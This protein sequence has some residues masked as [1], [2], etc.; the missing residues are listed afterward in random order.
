MLDFVEPREHFARHLPGVPSS[1][2]FH[3]VRNSWN[4]RTAKVRKVAAAIEKRLPEGWTTK[5]EA[6]GAEW[7]GQLVLQWPNEVAVDLLTSPGRGPQEADGLIK[8]MKEQEDA[9]RKRP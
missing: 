6:G 5:V 8:K 7:D 3:H 1:D 9:W 2:T 4:S